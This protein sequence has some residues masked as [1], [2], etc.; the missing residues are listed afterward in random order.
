MSS[1][2][3]ITRLTVEFPH[4]GNVEI[5]IDEDSLLVVSERWYMRLTHGTLCG[6]MTL[7]DKGANRTVYHDNFEFVKNGSERI[8]R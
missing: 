2:Q 7:I 6:L 3:A 1:Q 8:E 4:G 5:T